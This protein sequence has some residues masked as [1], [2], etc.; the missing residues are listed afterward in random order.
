MG[1]TNWGVVIGRFQLD[2]LTEAHKLLLAKVSSKHPRVVVFIGVRAGCSTSNDPLDYATREKMI[3]AE[4]PNAIISPLRDEKYDEDWSRNLDNKILEIT[5]S[6]PADITLYGGRD[7]FATSYLGRFSV[8]ELELEVPIEISASKVRAFITDN[9]MSSSDFRAGAIYA[10]QQNFPKVYTTVD[11]APIHGDE[12]LLGKKKMDRGW[13]FPG[14]FVEVQSE[15]SS[16]EENAKR[17]LQEETA[18]SVSSIH[19]ITS[20]VINDWR[21]KGSPDNIMTTFFLAHTTDLAARASDDLD[22]V[23]WFKLADVNED[24]FEGEHAQLWKALKSYLDKE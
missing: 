22:S 7:S 16:L 10:L 21:Y 9:V 11:I 23:K 24:M 1:K 15:D 3:R 13:R 12:I 4:V 6:I 18:L 5:G 20:H 19:Y 2:N 8:K 14:G 17:E